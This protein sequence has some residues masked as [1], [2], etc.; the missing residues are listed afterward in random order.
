MYQKDLIRNAWKSAGLYD[1]N[2][3]KLQQFLQLLDDPAQC[4]SELIATCRQSYADYKAKLVPPIMETPDTMVHLILIRAVDGPDELALLEQ[5]ISATDPARD[6]VE[7]KTI[8]LKNVPRLNRALAKKPG[9]TQ[10]VTDAMA[11]RSPARRVARRSRPARPAAAS[12]APPPS[13]PG[14]PS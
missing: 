2:D 7:L 6:E 11:A 13:A 10:P 12:P 14:S 8:A 3:A 1:E 4:W 5:Y 9:L